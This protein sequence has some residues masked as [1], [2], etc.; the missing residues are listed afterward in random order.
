MVVF[1]ATLV[2]IILAI[3]IG[4]NV[5][6]RN[7]ILPGFMA[8]LRRKSGRI[9]TGFIIVGLL[10]YIFVLSIG[11]FDFNQIGRA[12][13]SND[14]APFVS[15]DRTADTLT[16]GGT[17]S[18]TARRFYTDDALGWTCDNP[19]LVS[20]TD[21]P[22]MG[23]DSRVCTITALASGTVRF[24][25]A[26]GE[27]SAVATLTITGDNGA[28][29]PPPSSEGNNS[30]APSSAAAAPVVDAPAPTTPDTPASSAPIP[31]PTSDADTDA[32]AVKDV[33]IKHAYSVAEFQALG[34]TLMEL[35]E[36]GN[37]LGATEN[38]NV[39]MTIANENVCAVVWGEDVTLNDSTLGKSV[40]L[41]YPQMGAQVK[42]TSGGYR[43]FAFDPAFGG[44]LSV[45][46]DYWEEQLLRD[47]SLKMGGGDKKYILNAD[48]MEE[49]D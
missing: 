30:G 43:P 11:S 38:L 4:C 29:A 47:A 14:P 24:T 16:V 21:T 27:L 46:I 45:G 41:I 19:S 33:T 1:L 48:G 35:T 23:K 37:G 20:F 31:P 26:A 3:S 36:Y 17:T 2:V 18:F 44:G 12:R 25:A 15:L 13:D 32:E 8:F 5:Y 6:G 42:V 7:H 22:G 34:L 49:I 40:V 28:A 10:Y 39:N 9:I